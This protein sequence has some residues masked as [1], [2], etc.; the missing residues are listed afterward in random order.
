MKYPPIN[1][2]LLLILF[3]LTF[4]ACDSSEISGSETFNLIFQM[5]TVMIDP[6]DELLFLN[7]NLNQAKISQDRQFLYNYNWRDMIIEKINLDD[8]T[9][10]K[11]ITLAKEGPN[12]VGDNISGI[13]ILENNQLLLSGR[14]SFF[15]VDE[16][17]NLID[18]VDFMKMPESG[19]L[20]SD[21]LGAQ[22]IFNS[23][24]LILYGVLMNWEENLYQITKVD[25]DKKGIEKIDH[26]SFKK[27]K[28]YRISFMMDGR[29]AGGYGPSVF[30]GGSPNNIILN[31]NISN[32]AISIKG[33]NSTPLFNS[34]ESQLFPD[35]RKNPSKT[36]VE[37][38]DELRKLVRE[39]EN[40]IGFS[41]FI[42][43]DS[44]QF[45][46]FSYFGKTK[47]VTDEEDPPVVV[48]LSI[49]D[50]DLNLTAESK[51][52]QLEFRPSLFFYKDGRIWIFKNM[53]DEMAFVRLSIE[54]N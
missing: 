34:F 48:F 39:M 46:R 9:F 36:E 37:S 45:Y 7:S 12:G 15:W 41:N 51:V 50:Q 47:D 32:E 2:A 13:H 20:A 18:K 8:L 30:V 5:D 10:E 24:E 11:G 27:L 6:K 21:F 25:L 40:D 54:K 52:D 38:W 33:Q 43:D 14:N 26:E 1:Q 29:T 3:T 35:L 19:L 49:F 28:D 44:G 22:K 4:S 16:D 23:E 42:A 17:G 31:T 53:D